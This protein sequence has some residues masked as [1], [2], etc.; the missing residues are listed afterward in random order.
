MLNSFV[1]CVVLAATRAAIRDSNPVRIR[2]QQNSIA[3]VS[4]FALSAYNVNVRTRYVFAWYAES[5]V[6]ME[7]CEMRGATAVAKKKIK[8][9]VK[10]IAFRVKADYDKWLTEYAEF[11]RTTISALIDRALVEMAE[12]DEFKKPPVRA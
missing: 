6:L 10:S 1:D 7:V 11:K 12:R 4:D 9:T 5:L 8:V 3:I 2:L